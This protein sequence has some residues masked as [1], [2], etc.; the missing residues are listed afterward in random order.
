MWGTNIGMGSMAR[1]RGW[2]SRQS[3]GEVAVGKKGDK[4]SGQ[5]KCQGPEQ[6]LESPGQR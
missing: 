4:R 6:K 2:R 3:L 1:M 5:A